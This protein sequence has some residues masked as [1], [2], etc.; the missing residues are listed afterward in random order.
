MLNENSRFSQVPQVD[1]GRSTFDET[2]THTTTLDAGKLVP[3]FCQEVLPG[4]TFTLNTA[5]VAR[6]STPIYPVMDDCYVDTYY[7]FV[8]N[9][10]V[11]SHWKEFMGENS[12]GYWKQVEEDRHQ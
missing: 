7:F 12:S 3:I 4:D 9:R 6:M 2:H 5:T 11:W 8:P 1:I 10:L